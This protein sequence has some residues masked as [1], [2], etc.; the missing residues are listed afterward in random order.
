MKEIL[1]RNLGYKIISLVFAVFFW[2]WITS[3]GNTSS[4]FGINSLNVPL[5]TYNQP[6]NLVVLS[7]IPTI[8]VRL[9]SESPS[10][11]VE[12]LYA[13]VDL[14]NATAGEHS[15]EV[16]IETPEEVDVQDISPRNVVLRLDTVK[17]KI[18]PVNVSV[19]GK[20]AN[21]FLI[22]EPII[23][24]P[25]VNVRGPSS[26]LEE[27]ES[28]S[29]EVNVAGAEET[30]QVV[31]GVTFKD[32]K[33]SGLFAP[34]PNLETLNPFPETVEVIVPVYSKGTASKIVSLKATTTGTP[35]PGLT[36]RMV[37]PLPSKVQLLGSQ[38]ALKGINT[39]NLGAVDVSGLSSNKVFTINSENIALPEGVGM[40]EGIT[41]KVMVYIGPSIQQKTLK[42]IPV[43]I[44]NIPDGLK[45]Q[46]IGSIDVQVSGYPDILNAI[47]AGDIKVWVDASG[48]EAGTYSG[49]ELF[50]DVPSGVNMVSVPKVNLTLIA[51]NPE[52]QQPGDQ[53][54]E[55]QG[56]SGNEN[57][58]GADNKTGPQYSLPV[59]MINI[60]EKENKEE[61]SQG[62]RSETG[63]TS[64]ETASDTEGGEKGK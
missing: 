13:Y 45:A 62:S 50:W 21:G 27:L 37:T 19:T 34:D 28:V 20:Q 58:A 30:L 11:S 38:E 35:A 14:K 33:G 8:N 47:K 63:E 60:I 44:R 42:G 52:E 2:L 55:D 46:P 26:I 31:R 24:P 4:L 16:Q 49:T 18:V 54:G 36:V 6:P 1:R 48:L 64:D 9:D 56:Q 12:D 15:F 61:A 39:I 7:S 43:G 57:E 29:V 22:G 25:V 23:T 5:V 17:D 59:Q 51:L 10:V 32:I 3:Q 40:T 53:T 41:I